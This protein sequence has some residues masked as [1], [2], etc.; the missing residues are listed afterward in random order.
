MPKKDE[1]YPARPGSYMRS[2]VNVRVATGSTT[3]FPMSLSAVNDIS[4]SHASVSN[5]NRM[6]YFWKCSTKNFLPIWPMSCSGH[7]T[8]YHNGCS[9]QGIRMQAQV[10]W[11]GLID[12]GNSAFE[13]LSNCLGVCIITLTI[14]QWSYKVMPLSGWARLVP[15]SSYRNIPRL[16]WSEVCW[17]LRRD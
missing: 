5:F 1:I 8:R 16:K 6:I 7:V 4:H 13:H 9:Q 17:L 3:Y 11:R 2:Y 10:S 15:G 12:V 14:G